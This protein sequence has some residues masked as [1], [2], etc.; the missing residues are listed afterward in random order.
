[1]SARKRDRIGGGLTARPSTSVQATADSRSSLGTCATAPNMGINASGRG[2][3]QPRTSTLSKGIRT[4]QTPLDKGW[5]GLGRRSSHFPS[6]DVSAFEAE[7]D[8]KFYTS[9][10][11]CHFG[12]IFADKRLIQPT[13]MRVTSSPELESAKVCGGYGKRMVNGML[14]TD[15][16]DSLYGKHKPRK[17]GV[18]AKSKP[19]RRR[20][21]E[22]RLAVSPD[23]PTFF[24]LRHTQVVGQTLERIR[25]PPL[26]KIGF[27]KLIIAEPVVVDDG[28]L[29]PPLD[30]EGCEEMPESNWRD[31]STSSA[32]PTPAEP[33][34]LSSYQPETRR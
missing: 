30:W 29:L 3:T 9:S 24:Q 34:P 20:D 7:P 27:G 23:A 5:G 8:L 14:S 18:L 11:I 6:I 17:G 10:A 13:W 15:D 26:R 33:P 19:S 32:A 21:G 28:D 16:Y 31:M 22:S 4:G 1:M 2:R 25:K 12:R